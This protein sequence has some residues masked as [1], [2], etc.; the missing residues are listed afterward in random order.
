M[1]KKWKKGGKYQ[2]KYCKTK[3]VAD[4]EGIPAPGDGRERFL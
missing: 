4:S 2:G 3:P 1:K